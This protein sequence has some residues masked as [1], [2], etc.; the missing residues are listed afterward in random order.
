MSGPGVLVPADIRFPLE[1]A[2]GVQ[3]VK[4]AAALART[5]TPTTLLV[6][7]SDPRPTAEVLAGYGVTPHPC[8]RVRRLAVLHRRGSYVLPRGSFLLRALAASSRALL[9]GELVFTRDLQ[10]A[11]LLVRLPRRGA[12]VYEAHAVEALMYTERAALYGSAE[13]ADPAKARRLARRETRVWRRAGAFV[14]TTAGIRDAFVEAHGPRERVH[15]V[16][17]GCDVPEDRRFPGLAAERPPRVLYAGQLYPWKG[18]D[19]LVQAMA[20]VPGARLVILGGLAGEVDLARVQARVEALGL[21]GRTEMPGTRP[22]AEVAAELARA[23]VVAVPFL[24]SAMT[25]RHTSPI[26]AFEALAAGRPLVATDLPSTREFLRDGENALLVPAG[27]APALAAAI[28]R[29]L[30]D[31]ALAERLARAA[32]AAAPA[33]SWDARGRTLRA[34]F[35]EVRR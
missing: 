20:L 8:L 34:L 3:I 26:K 18:V 11:D 7:R 33:F 27:D 9:R 6:R 23:A 13:R 32:W 30:E 14:A 15:V 21:A 1:R 25:E 28:R 35:D 2:N 22:Q 24:R 5:G 16:P 10:L 17:N 31:H 4:T 29:V 19:V 12:V